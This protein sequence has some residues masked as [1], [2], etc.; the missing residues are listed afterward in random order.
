MVVALP[1]RLA[2]VAQLQEVD[3]VHHQVV[4]ELTEVVSTD[5][6]QEAHTLQHQEDTDPP[7]VLDTLG[8]QVLLVARILIHTLVLHKVAVQVILT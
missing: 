6:L 5:H 1:R 4:L 7:K 3:T 2:M 8:P